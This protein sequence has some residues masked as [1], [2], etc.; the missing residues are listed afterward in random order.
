MTDETPH[1]TGSGL[2]PVRM[3]LRVIGR[4]GHRGGP[5]LARAVAEARA[6][7][8]LDASTRLA[9]HAAPE[10]AAPPAAA[11]PA[12]AAPAATEPAASP[13]SDVRSELGMSDFAKEFLFGDA[14]AATS[15]L[16]PMSAAS[17]MPE[18]TSAKE[19]RLAR[20]RARGALDVSRAAK[21]LEGAA[22]GALTGHETEL[23]PVPSPAG[24]V[25]A[26]AGQR[27]SRTPADTPKPPN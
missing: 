12:Y 21:I 15:G 14:S 27:V 11:T 23:P 1:T 19:A 8:H 5:H 24:P 9:R 2:P 18:G 17:T 20:R 4:H 25:P 10:A 3:A 6:P 7:K 16:T 13:S 22:D 26:S